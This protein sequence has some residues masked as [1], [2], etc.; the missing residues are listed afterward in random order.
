MHLFETQACQCSLAPTTELQRFALSFVR[1]F[2]PVYYLA[3]SGS[4]I[5]TLLSDDN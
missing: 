3:V 4:M 5:Y 2:T 1:P